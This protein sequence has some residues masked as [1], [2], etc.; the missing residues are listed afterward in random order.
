MWVEVTFEIAEEPADEHEASLRR[1]AEMLTDDTSS[2]MVRRVDD[3]ER[4]L[5]AT[6]FTMPQ[7]AQGA[8]VGRIQ[9]RFRKLGFGCLHDCPDM[10][11]TLPRERPRRR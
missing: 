9:H 4:Y 11:I 5:L 3:R 1:D 6:S 2:V 8:V 7:A 10:W